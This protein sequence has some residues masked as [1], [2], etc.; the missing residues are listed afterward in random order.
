VPHFLDADVA[1]GIL[2]SRPPLPVLVS[3]LRPRLRPEVALV[4]GGAADAQG[5]EVVLLVVGG[6]QVGV[7]EVGQLAALEGVGVDRCG[8]VAAVDADHV[9]T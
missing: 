3:R 1:A 6:V 4:P 7:A 5:D 8:T 9:A 2:A